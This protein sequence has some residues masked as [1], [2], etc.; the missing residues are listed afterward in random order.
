MLVMIVPISLLL[1]QMGLWYQS[2]PLSPGEETVV[3]VKLNDN[4]ALLETSIISGET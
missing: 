2:R 3:T 4:I 1:A